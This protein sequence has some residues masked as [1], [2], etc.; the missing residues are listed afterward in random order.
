MLCNILFNVRWMFI[1]IK[2][3][4]DPLTLDIVCSKDKALDFA[5]YIYFHFDL[6][7]KIFSEKVRKPTYTK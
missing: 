7:S 4:G 3:E 2:L 6:C 1:P 5:F